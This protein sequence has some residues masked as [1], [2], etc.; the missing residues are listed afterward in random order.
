M[1]NVKISNLTTTWTSSLN[2]YEGI[3]LNA[4]NINSGPNT[5]LLHLLV[6]SLTKFKVTKNGL[7]FATL[8]SGSFDGTASWANNA[9][10]AINAAAANSASYSLTS[11]YSSNTTSASYASTASYVFNAN[12]YNIKTVSS[13]Y[14]MML[15]DY[16]ILCD[17]ISG[18]FNVVLPQNTQGY[19]FNIKKID[20]SGNVINVYSYDGS[21]IDYDFTQSILHRGTNMQLQSDGTKYWLL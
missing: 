8:F 9:V 7:V 4:A 10:N 3:R 13:S 11:S 19:I 18:S 20:A 15:N 14:T 21:K 1:A 5:N 16:T 17:A 2:D 12:H 6:D